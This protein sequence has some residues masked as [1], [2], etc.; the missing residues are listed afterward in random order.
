[1]TDDNIIDISEQ[2]PEA[3]LHTRFLRMTDHALELELLR[4]KS[5][6]GVH[7]SEGRYC[8]ARGQDHPT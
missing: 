5:S 8:R 6:L 2:L 3:D 7:P 4:S 1:M